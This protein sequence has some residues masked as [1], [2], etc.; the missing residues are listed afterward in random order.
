MSL[1]D[2]TN[3][4]SN[5]ETDDENDLINNEYTA[6]N[7]F[8]AGIISSIYILLISKF[9]Q[10]MSFD[11]ADDD[12]IVDEKKSIGTYVM[13]IY[14]ISIIGMV[15]SY[16]YFKENSVPDFIMKWSINI[17]SMMILIY[18]VLNYWDY[19]DIT[20]FLLLVW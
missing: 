16:I 15:F 7:L 5:N 13:I 20:I 10:V 2:N 8:I 12:S 19:L 4:I 11:S 1:I 14:F 3:N 17:G 18:T 9:A 6:H